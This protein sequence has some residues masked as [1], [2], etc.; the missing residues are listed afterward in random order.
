MPERR[1]VQAEV[2]LPTGATLS[3]VRAAKTFETPEVPQKQWLEC[4]KCH[5]TFWSLKQ[6]A[7]HAR[8]H[9]PPL[10]ATVA[11]APP[12]NEHIFFTLHF[13]G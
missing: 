7:A 5:K 8:K 12:Y 6:A 2:W 9:E 1:G 4:K 11:T 10:I 13:R 3:G